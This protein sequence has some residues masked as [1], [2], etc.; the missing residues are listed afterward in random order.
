[1]NGKCSRERL[2]NGGIGEGVLK[3]AEFVISHRVAQGDLAEKV[4]CEYR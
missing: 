4:T 2:S 1:M 3:R